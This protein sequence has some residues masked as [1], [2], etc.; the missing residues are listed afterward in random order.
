MSAFTDPRLSRAWK[1]HKTV[2]NLMEKL[3]LSIET[4]LTDKA[5]YSEESQEQLEELKSFRRNV[6]HDFADVQ[7]LLQRYQEAIEQ[8][9]TD[10]LND[11]DPNDDYELVNNLLEGIVDQ[12]AHT[13]MLAARLMRKKG[14]RLSSLVADV[15]R[16]SSSASSETLVSMWTNSDNVLRV[17]LKFVQISCQQCP[18]L[19]RATPG[20]V[21]SIEKRYHL[22]AA[23]CNINLVQRKAFSC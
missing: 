23:G 11:Y 8:L 2:N 16:E 17:E 15:A 18:V 20:L 19:G 6:K 21:C 3:D 7:Q 4:L 1:Q 22:V 13:R 14:G 12:V 10:E 5:G 9:N